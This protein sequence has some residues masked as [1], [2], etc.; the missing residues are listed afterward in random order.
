MK[1]IKIEQI[2]SLGF[3]YF[4]VRGGNLIKSSTKENYN[5]GND[6]CDNLIGC[7]KYSIKNK[8]EKKNNSTH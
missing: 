2:R 7:F 1:E 5:L 4:I 3:Y 8:L 6:E